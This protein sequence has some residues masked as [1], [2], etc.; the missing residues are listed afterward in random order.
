MRAVVR[1]LMLAVL[2]WFVAGTA[3][4]AASAAAMDVKMALAGTGDMQMPD[5]DGCAGDGDD[6]ASCDGACVLPLLANLLPVEVAR[7]LS[8]DPREIAAT[9]ELIGRTGPPDLHPPRFIS[10]S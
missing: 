6:G 4:N 5:C 3:V 10:L 8:S 1:I 9:D 2:V 7:R